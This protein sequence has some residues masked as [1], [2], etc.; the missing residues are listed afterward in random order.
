MGKQVI[1]G[2]DCGG[3]GQSLIEKGPVALHPLPVFCGLRPQTESWRALGVKVLRDSTRTSE[4]EGF[5]VEQGK[6]DRAPMPKSDERRKDQG[7]A[8]LGM[9]DSIVLDEK[10]PQLAVEARRK[11][12]QDGV[13]CCA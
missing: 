3:E 4:L 9:L 1:I 2:E 5:A 6:N 10:A 13:V 8:L 11:R 12:D 7:V